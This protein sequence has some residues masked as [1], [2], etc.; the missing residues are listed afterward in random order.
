MTTQSLASVD[1]MSSSWSIE[2]TDHYV[3]DR[4]ACH[5]GSR[6]ILTFNTYVDGL[7]KEIL[8]HKIAEYVRRD[9]QQ[10]QAILDFMLEYSIS[11]SDLSFDA[12]KKAMQR[13]KKKKESK[14][15]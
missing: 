10:K 2:I 7:M 12:W 11:E 8:Y 6:N 3:I 13:L 4:G 5:L 15:E 1:Q 14:S 9:E